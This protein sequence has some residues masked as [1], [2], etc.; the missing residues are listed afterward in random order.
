MKPRK[1]D[2][3][4]CRRCQLRR[5]L[6]RVRRGRVKHDPDH[7]LCFRCFRSVKDAAYHGD[8][9]RNGKGN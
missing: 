3:K 8:L 7:D 4:L 1:H 5:A 6:F 2:P 9:E